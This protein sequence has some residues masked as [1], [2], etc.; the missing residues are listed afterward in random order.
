MEKSTAAIF[1]IIALLFSAC[2]DRVYA[3]ALY[4]TDIAYQYKPMSSD[5]VKNA[6]YISGSLNV[7]NAVNQSD[8]TFIGRAG[9]GRANTFNNFNLAYGAYGFLGDYQNTS[10]QNNQLGYFTN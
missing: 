9:L 8:A 1:F 4:K 3:P 10:I 5:A 6:N 2:T 7:G